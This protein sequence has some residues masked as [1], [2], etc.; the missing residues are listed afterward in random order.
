MEPRKVKQ[1]FTVPS[2]YG[3][4]SLSLTWRQELDYTRTC[5][6]TWESTLTRTHLPPMQ[7]P[8]AEL[9]PQA[10]LGA[11]RKTASGMYHE[12]ELQS[13]KHTLFS[14]SVFTVKWGD[15]HSL[16]LLRFMMQTPTLRQQA[17]CPALRAT[18]KLRMLPLHS[19]PQTGSCFH[20][21]ANEYRTALSE[22]CKSFFFP[23]TDERGSSLPCCVL[24]LRKQ[25][26]H[27]EPGRFSE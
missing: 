9:S 14:G 10:L 7:T 16:G 22:T 20:R 26:L 4:L 21:T 5:F 13:E 18:F 17:S 23:Q 1:D 19:S 12:S 3:T 2:G 6:N 27:K 11:S 24:S 8:P 25:M 15:L